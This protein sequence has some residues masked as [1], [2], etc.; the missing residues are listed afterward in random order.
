MFNLDKSEKLLEL[1]QRT[2]LCDGGIFLEYTGICFANQEKQITL[3]TANAIVSMA[4]LATI[5]LAK[6]CPVVRDPEIRDPP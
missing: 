2:T 3:K 6:A 1:L 4:F 5:S